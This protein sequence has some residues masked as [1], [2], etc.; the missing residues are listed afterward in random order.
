MRT[1]NWTALLMSLLVLVMVGC[2]GG[3]GG[4]GEPAGTALS[5]TA[6]KGPIVG[7]TVQVFEIVSSATLNPRA[8]IPRYGTTPLAEDTTDSDGRYNVTIPGAIASGSLLVRITGGSYLDEATNLPKNVATEF[9]ATGLRA[10]F[11]YTPG[12]PASAAV[13]P[14][15]EMAVAD[16]GPN[17]TVAMIAASNAKIAQAFGLP[18]IIRTAPLDPTKPF[19]AGATS[20]AQQYALALATVSQYQKDFGAGQSMTQIFT[21]LTTQI[22]DPVNSGGLAPAT[23]TQ[24]DASTNNF[25]GGSNNPNPVLNTPTVN[26]SAPAVVQT[27]LSTQGTA[28]V[29]TSVTVTAILATT[30]GTPVPDGTVVSFSTSAG[31]LSA[32]SATTVNGQATVTLTSPTAGTA[33]VTVNSGSASSVTGIT[34]VNPSDPPPTPSN[35]PAG[36]T[37]AASSSPGFTTGPAVVISANVTRAAGDAV[38]DGTS[39]SFSI[40]S[41]SGTLSAA[42]ATTTGGVATVS[43][44]SSTAGASVGVRGVAGSVSAQLSVPFVAPPPTNDPAGITLSV[45]PTSGFTTGPAVVVTA[46]VVRSTGAAVPDGTAVSFSVVSGSGTLSAASATTTGGVSTVS[47]SS[48]VAGASVG[49]RAAAGTVSATIG[50]PF[51]APTQAIVKVRSSGTLASG[52][53]IGGINATVTYATNKGLSIAPSAV[54]TSGAGVGALLEKNTNNQGQVVLGLITTSGI[55]LGE[56]ATLTFT[57]AGGAFPV[58]ADFGIAAGA[59]VIDTAAGTLPGVTAEILSVTVQ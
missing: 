38:P 28:P 5:G 37:L 41:G 8:N 43:L 32:P 44:S 25:A 24:I 26:P 18:D 27:T 31:T 30:D 55:G 52:T 10:I 53:L 48:S 56:F 34:F 50:V 12:T 6:M 7:G 15:T 47:L 33:T 29:S 49:L 4:T 59:Q 16:M 46:N 45:N 20:A 2:G 3:G 19:P 1:R 42:T 23:E 57:I 22:N 58:S 9:G 36:I 51:I 35:D 21:A 11:G 39:V 17:P 40:V 54:V 13:T 14:F